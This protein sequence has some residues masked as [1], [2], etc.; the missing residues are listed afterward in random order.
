MADKNSKQPLNVPGAWYVDTTCTMCRTC[1]EEAPN[2]LKTNDDET[3]VY[4][5]KQPE[6]DA[7]TAAAQR[8][9]EVCPTLAIANDGCDSC[10]T[11]QMTQKYFLSNLLFLAS[12]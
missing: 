6:G 7:E 1:L 10:Q 2:L 5:V 8:S 3:A 4:F 11:R 12:F 9:M